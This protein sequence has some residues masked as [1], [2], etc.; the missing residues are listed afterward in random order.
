V[1]KYS[2]PILTC[3]VFGVGH[4]TVFLNY[5]LDRQEFFAGIIVIKVFLGKN[6]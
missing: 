5:V 3:S 1:K 6:M 2:M 4:K